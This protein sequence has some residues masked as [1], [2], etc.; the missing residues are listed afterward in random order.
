MRVRRVNR[1]QQKSCATT[2]AHLCGLVSCSLFWSAARSRSSRLVFE[3]HKQP[4]DLQSAPRKLVKR[5]ANEQAF[6]T[7]LVHL[8][9]DQ[10]FVRL[11]V[12]RLFG[13]LEVV[14]QQSPRLLQRQLAAA[15]AGVSELR[16]LEANARRTGG[17]PSCTR[18]GA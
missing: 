13:Q 8:V 11:L 14:L 7:R 1:S 4:H 12:Q 15:G 5:E 17:G 6:G 18:S 3:S 2:A 10:A 9:L 16:A